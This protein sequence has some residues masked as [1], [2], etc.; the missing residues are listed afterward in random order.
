MKRRLFSLG[1]CILIAACGG[2]PLRS[3]PR[4]MQLP[5]QLLEANPAEFR[6]ALQVDARLVPPAGAVPFLIIK[7]APRTAGEFE[8]I[9]KRLALQL[10]VASVSTLGLEAPPRGRRWLVYSMPPQTQLELQRVQETIRQS[11]AKSQTL[12]TGKGGGSLSVGLEQDSLAT[13]D[14]ALAGSRWDTWLQ[15]HQSDGFFEVWSG[16]LAQLK[17]IAAEKK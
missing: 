7:V 16:T 8:I 9:D 11:R 5:E 3:L 1:T 2:V 6:V 13:S 17:K 10:S 15:T 4:L 14:P 12:P